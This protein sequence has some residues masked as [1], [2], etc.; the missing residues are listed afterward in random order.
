MSSAYPCT[1]PL[2]T[3]RPPLLPQVFNG[4]IHTIQIDLAGG[5]YLQ[6]PLYPDVE[7]NDIIHVFF[8]SNDFPLVSFIIQTLPGLPRSFLFPASVATVGPHFAFYVAED[9]A[10]NSSISE[11]VDFQIVQSLQQNSLLTATVLANNALAD[12]VSTNIVRATLYDASGYPSSGQVLRLT[13]S[14]QAQHP[15]FVV[16]DVTGNAFI[17][18]T[19]TVPGVVIL[20]IELGTNPAT[21]TSAQVMFTVPGQSICR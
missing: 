8:S 21:S 20:N 18:I 19:N 17:P 4:V 5:L 13:A 11:R 16:T 15:Q 3:L 9:F 1:R 7:I 12:G 14:G 2:F 6:V 10:G